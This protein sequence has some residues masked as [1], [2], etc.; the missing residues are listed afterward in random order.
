M[1]MRLAGR[2]LVLRPEFS[3]RLYRPTNSCG[4]MQEERKR[5]RALLKKN[6]TEK[7][8]FPLMTNSLRFCGAGAPR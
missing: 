1:G 8:E 4:W 7:R 2:I 3:H 6:G 5:T